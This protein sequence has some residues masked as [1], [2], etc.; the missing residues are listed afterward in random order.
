MK[1]TILSSVV[2]LLSMVSTSLEAID[3]YCKFEPLSDS[4]YVINGSDSES[5]PAKQLVHP[6]TNPVAIIGENGVVLV[7]PGSSQQVGRLVVNRL[8]SIT[9]KP[10]IAIINTHIHGLYWLAND[11]IKQ[12]YPGAVIYAHQ[13]MIDR[14]KDGEG[15]FWV[16][17]ITGNFKGDRTIMAAPEQALSDGELLN[18]NGIDIKIHHPGHAH[19]NHDLLLEVV[20]DKILILGGL[21]V[22]PE[23]PSQ[24][25][26]QDADFRGQIAA[27]KYA[28]NLDMELYIPGQGFPQG[29]ELPRRGLQFLQAVYSGVER[30]Y[31]EDLQDYVITQQLKVELAGYE[32]WYDFSGMGAVVS[33]MYLQVEQDSF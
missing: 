17:A 25:V 23:V 12:A 7:D 4:V 10:V 29:Q 11:A 24:G 3:I 30:S 8:R 26:P 2:I 14:I 31:Q 33:E 6:V 16:E 19:T 9:D 32:Q 5:C 28:I 1:S 22:E 20:K 13:I 27:T 15:L 21:V 18:I